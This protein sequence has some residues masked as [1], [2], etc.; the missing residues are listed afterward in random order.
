ME[1]NIANSRREIGELVKVF[2]FTAGVIFFLLLLGIRLRLIFY[3]AVLAFEKGIT[4]PCDLMYL[5]KCETVMS[6]QI[7]RWKTLNNPQ[8]AL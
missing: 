7:I 6:C 4:C 3:I 1:D 2:T 8:T 5:V